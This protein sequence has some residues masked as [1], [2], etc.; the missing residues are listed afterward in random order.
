MDLFTIAAKLTVDSGAFTS[1]LNKADS[2]GSNLAGKLSKITSVAKKVAAALVFKKGIDQLKSLADKAAA[3]G[4]RIDKNSQKIGMSRKAYQQ[5][6]YIMSQCGGS[7]DDVGAAMKNL[8]SKVQAGNPLIEK[9]GLNMED[10]K[11]LNMED[12]FS[13]VVEAF[14]KM[15]EGAEKSALAVELFGKK[16]QDL[17]PLLNSAPGSLEEMKNRFHDL[18]IE[19]TD[20][21]ID[22]AVNYTDTM[23]NLNRV[24]D[25]GKVLIGSALLPA[26]QKLAE[27]GVQYASKL[28]KAFKGE[29]GGRGG[30]A[31]VLDA[32]TTSITEGLPEITRQAKEI[33]KTIASSIAENAPKILKA[34][35]DIWKAIGDGLQETDN[36]ILQGVGYVMNFIHDL[37][38]DPEGTLKQAFSDLWEGIKDVASAAWEGIKALASAAWESI[39]GWWLENIADPVEAAWNAVKDK[40]ST[41]WNNIKRFADDTWTAIKGLWQENIAKPVEK[42]WNE[43][44]EKVSTVWDNIKRYA[45]EAWTAIKGFW[46]ENIS[47]PVE[48][49][50]KSVKEK[51]STVW[52]NIKRYA[53]DAWTAI[54]GFWQENISGPVEKAWNAVKDKAVA[55]WEAI[56]AAA[57]TLWDAVKDAVTTPIRVARTALSGVWNGIKE[58]ATSIWNGL[59]STAKSIWQSI[60]D[61]IATPIR[62]VRTTLAGVWNGIKE[63]AT[64]VWNAIKST[65]EPIISGISSVIETLSSAVQSVVNWLESLFGF[66]GKE[67]YTKSFHSHTETVY[68]NIVNNTPEATEDNPYPLLNAPAVDPFTGQPSGGQK[69]WADSYD[70][71]VA[72][73][74][75]GSSQ[76]TKGNTKGLD[77]SSLASTIVDAIK[78]GMENAQVNSY[79][80]GKKVTDEVSKILGNNMT[81]RRFA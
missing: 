38:T 53:D 41:V 77:L 37:F 55:V 43:V 16:G 1:G 66:N 26:F 79:L 69:G 8:N 30:L 17:M 80:N 51:V 64:S 2:A 59:K 50:W 35:G 21:Q 63:K 67:V 4:D 71:Y 54:K 42:A 32:V 24:L 27:K 40:V 33:V 25:T 28:L 78:S 20:S 6:D 62:T 22:A 7:V 13:A 47:E 76:A 5:W 44:K 58:K 36:P 29:D 34:M 10:V 12:R 52:D 14:Q 60:K 31:G 75:S 45:D 48:K 3:A 72:T 57:K 15:P 23:D 65:V 18:G 39:K 46:Q 19:L 73:L 70:G 9:L 49:A 56:K 61:A 68:Q 11:N 81:A 74:R